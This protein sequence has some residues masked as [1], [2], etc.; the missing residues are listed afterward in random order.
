MSNRGQSVPMGKI[1]HIGPIITICATACDG[2]LAL[3][4]AVEPSFRL[5]AAGVVADVGPGEDD[6]CVVTGAGAI[7]CWGHGDAG[8]PATIESFVLPSPARQIGTGLGHRVALT[9]AGEVYAW[10]SIPDES[11]GVAPA[12]STNASAFILA[13]VP[14]SIELSGP[15]V[16]VSA[17]ADFAC[18]RML[19]GDVRCWG[20]NGCGQLGRDDIDRIGNDELPS[21][22]QPIELAGVAIHVTAGAQHACAVLDT[23]LVQCWGRNEEGQLGREHDGSGPVVDEI[24]LGHAVIAVAAGE[25]HTC[26][27]LET[28]AIRCWGSNGSGRLGHGSSVSTQTKALASELPDVDVGGTAI[29]LVAGA[30][31]TCALLEDRTIRCWGDNQHGQLGLG[32]TGDVGDDELPSEVDPLDLGEH[33]GM[34]VLAGPTANTTFAVLDHGGLRS[35]GLNDAGQLGHGDLTDVGDEPQER[36]GELPDILIDDPYDDDDG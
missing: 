2:E 23:G 16:E 11:C 26:A 17:G 22:S 14:S 6:T 19:D 20:N 8:A 21:A 33:L 25:A 18:A 36:P 13:L 12:G 10:G 5:G 35:W 9:D 29:D 15:A 31:H 30:R 28:G 4:G 24:D 34:A 7:A 27:L 1:A 32:H 3:D